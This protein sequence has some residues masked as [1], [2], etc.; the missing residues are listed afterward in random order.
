LKS[1]QTLTPPSQICQKGSMRRRQ[2]YLQCPAT[3]AN[4]E[5]WCR[6]VEDR[7]GLRTSQSTEDLQKKGNTIEVTARVC[8]TVLACP[9]HSSEDSYPPLYQ[10]SVLEWFF[11]FLQTFFD[12]LCNFNILVQLND[13]KKDKTGS[14]YENNLFPMWELTLQTKSRIIELFNWFGKIIQ[15][16]D[17]LS[18]Q[19][20]NISLLKNF[21][22]SCAFLGAIFAQLFN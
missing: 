2:K 9:P 20:H 16:S 13:P 8:K 10:S 15:M 19:L 3:N 17:H 21:W 1:E 4:Q 22:G 5:S 11:F 12:I 18:L 14:R 7:Q 6:L